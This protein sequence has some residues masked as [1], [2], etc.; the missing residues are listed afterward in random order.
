MAKITRYV[1]A[2]FE[3]EVPKTLAS[4]KNWE[5]SSG[6][7]TGEDFKVFTRLFKNYIKKLMSNANLVNFSPNHYTFSGFFE[8]NGKYVYFSISDVRF[9]KNQWYNHI[10]IRTATSITDY[11]GGSNCYTS[12][13]DFAENINKLLKYPLP[14]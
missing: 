4:F 8:L 3:E 6:V 13:E 10:L 5:F 7:Y 14:L 12:L 9:F 2:T 1:T 11:T